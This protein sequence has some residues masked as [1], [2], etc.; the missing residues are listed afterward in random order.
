MKSKFCYAFILITFMC[1]TAH[2]QGMTLGE[3]IVVSTS[4]L[5]K[6]SNAEAFRSYVN[7]DVAPKINKNNPSV[8]I[9]AFHADR[10]KRKG[11]LLLVFGA[12]KPSTRESFATGSPFRNEVIGASGKKPSDF[13][14]NTH[15]YTEYRLI[16]ADKFQTRP[17]IG[18]LGIHYIK[19]K[20]EKAAEF[21]KFVVEKLHPAVGNVLPDMHLMYYKAVAGDNAHSYITIFAI[22][23]VEARHKY[24]PEGAPETKPLKDAFKPFEGLAKE[25]SAYL[26]EG[27]YL[28][29]GKGGA[30]IFESKEWTD[31]IY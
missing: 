5:K 23:S 11:D 9:H 26:V 15:T 22:T 17:N 13:L 3:V 28:E 24:W 10:G 7:T 20:K 6:N 25:L 19:V 4:A 29:V 30:A 14:T 12:D 31:F 2:G 16:G 21:E 18:I 1:I 27:S 8:S